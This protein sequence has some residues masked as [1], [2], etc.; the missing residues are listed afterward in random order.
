MIYY[1]TIAQICKAQV[2]LKCPALGVLGEH[3]FERASFQRA[4][5]SESTISREHYFQRA[6]FWPQFFV[7]S[8]TG[9]FQWTDDM[10]IDCI[11][12]HHL[13]DKL[14]EPVTRS[15][16]R[17]RNRIRQC[18]REFRSLRGAVAARRI[19]AKRCRQ[20]LFALQF[21][22]IPDAQTRVSID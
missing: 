12:T 13:R 15:P 8:A 5:F 6:L 16:R 19:E 14:D 20:G 4:L 7:N 22:G 2:S 21:A 10:K 18:V 1:N 11:R 9:N 3:L 17:R